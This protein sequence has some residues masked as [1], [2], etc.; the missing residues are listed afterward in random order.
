M[1]LF[2]LTGHVDQES[3]SGLGWLGIFHKVNTLAGAA[4]T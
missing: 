2:S 3:T 1:Q 4:V